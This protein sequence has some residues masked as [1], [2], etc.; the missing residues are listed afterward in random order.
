M[1]P[2]DFATESRPVRASSLPSLVLCPL[3][4]L[5]MACGIYED[6]PGSVSADTGTAV[7]RGVQLFHSGKEVREAFEQV[8]LEAP[9]KFC[10]ADLDE[11]EKHFKGYAEDP[12]NQ[13]AEV[14]FT[15]VKIK[16]RL[17]ADPSDPTGKDICIE[18]T[19]DQ[20]RKVQGVFEIWDVKTGKMYAGHE[21]L[22]VHAM[23]L[24][25]YT[26]G[27][28]Q[29]YGSKTNVKPGG[30]IATYDYRRR[31]PGPAFWH[32]PWDT[33]TCETLLT[34]VRRRVAEIRGARALPHPGDH[35]AYC[36]AG[37]VSSCVTNVKITV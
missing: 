25:A 31:T 11:A 24:A 28:R 33:A 4:A 8:K 37:G 23:Q 27:F 10:N 34:T 20:V 13:S 2:E 7:H 18:G 5:L 12:R 3:K 16:F 1:N 26:L 22:N 35:C 29:L 14:P 19:A 17:P 9:E 32:A 30:I 15:E 36:P 6:R 21:L